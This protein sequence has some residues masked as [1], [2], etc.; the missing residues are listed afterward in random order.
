M[1]FDVEGARK[2]GYS[3]TEIADYLAQQQKFD[4]AA[5]RKDGYGDA[6]IIAHLSQT[7]AA[8]IGQFDRQPDSFGKRVTRG[9]GEMVAGAGQLMSRPVAAFGRSLEMPQAQAQ[10]LAAG[11]P[12]YGL[13]HSIN[14][15]THGSLGRYLQR[16]PEESDALV[17]EI[18]QAA[19]AGAP[20]GF[21]WG[22]AS[23]NALVTL[24]FAAMTGPAEG[25]L[26]LARVGAA[27]GGI[28]GAVSPVVNTDDGMSAQKAVQVVGHS[29]GGALLTPL[30]SGAIGLTSKAIGATLQNLKAGFAPSMTMSQ[31]RARIA[32]EL[33]AMGFDPS[34]L[35]G[36]YLDEVASQVKSALQAGGDLNP[37]TLANAAAAKS[38]GVDLTKGQ[39]SRDAVQYGNEAWLRQAKGGEA[40]AKQYT[41]ALTRLNQHLNQLQGDAGAPMLRVDAGQRAI[42]ALKQADAPIKARVDALYDQARGMVGQD[43]P[44]DQRTFVDGTMQ[45]LRDAG[46]SDKL[47][48]Q[49]VNVLNMLSQGK[50]QLTMREAQMMI[51]A[52]NGRIGATT[53]PVEKVALRAFKDQLDNAIY[54]T[55]TAEGQQAASAFKAARGAA[56]QRFKLFEQVPALQQA[57]EGEISPDEFVQQVVYRS[58]LKD[59]ANTKRF[60]RASSPDAWNQLKAQVVNDLRDAARNGSEDPAKFLSASYTKALKR[61]EDGGKLRLLFTPEEV[62]TL[63]AISRVGKA[64][65]EVPPGNV[66]TGF[67]G[68]AKAV[69]MLSSLASK[70]GMGV[71]VI[72]ESVQ[73][74]A[75]AVRAGAALKSP[76]LASPPPRPDLLPVGIARYAPAFGSPLL[77]QQT[78]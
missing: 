41:G 7:Q 8:K 4:A 68:T 62:Q 34:R 48:G 38:L 32:G 73:S 30:A 28:S 57:V 29:A 45:A 40:L 13:A 76:E 10:V 70:L 1:A 3:E 78:D 60:M 51:R 18:D 35:G 23:G 74:G 39:A 9:M 31:I 66:Q 42:D 19:A 6:D 16:S 77:N 22:R 64:V 67:A 50:A 56:S 25:A 21:D 59:L 46:V 53:D 24:P 65:Q 63:K 17:K 47:P 37:T 75:N 36:Q 15:L 49:F 72:S 55:G 12:L 69:G 61:L 20:E 11:N 44:L 54:S 2:E 71:E 52:A 58:P 43:T 5:A 26:G 33:N 14:D 27:Q